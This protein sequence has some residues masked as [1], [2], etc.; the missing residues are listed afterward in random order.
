M[1]N[2][3]PCIFKKL[4]GYKMLSKRKKHNKN[5]KQ[6]ERKTILTSMEKEYIRQDAQATSDLT[7][8]YMKEKVHETLNEATKV[9]LETQKNISNL[10][11]VE[12]K[13]LEDRFKAMSEEEMRIAAS[14][15]PSS[16]LLEALDKELQR[17]FELEKKVKTL[18]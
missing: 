10:T 4:G 2:I 9:V 17:L 6:E 15:I 7:E 12:R 11:T 18:L 13:E 16:I 8:I 14:V 5:P 1:V 3:A